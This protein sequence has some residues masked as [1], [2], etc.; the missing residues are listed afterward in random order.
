[1][2]GSRREHSVRLEAT[3]RDQIVDQNADVGLVPS[4][5]ESFAPDRQVRR[6]DA[7]DN[8]LRRGFLVTGRSVDLTR[9]KQ[10]RRLASSRAAASARSAG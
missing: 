1:M 10:A 9:E 8:S 2:L 3:L 7:G 4:Q 6:V 5:F